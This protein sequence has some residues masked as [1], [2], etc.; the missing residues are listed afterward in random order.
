MGGGGGDGW[1]RGRGG[2]RGRRGRER[3]KEKGR[4]RSVARPVW[5]SFSCF[6]FGSGGVFGPQKSRLNIDDRL[7]RVFL[8]FIFLCCNLNKTSFKY[9]CL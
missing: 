3:R 1:A 2:G 7:L 8:F 6:S 5:T 9:L 4:I